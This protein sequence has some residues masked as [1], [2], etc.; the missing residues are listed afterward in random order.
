MANHI[1]HSSVWLFFRS[2][3]HEV[4]ARAA[5]W[6]GKIFF[7]SFFLFFFF[8]PFWGFSLSFSG[9]L[10]IP[11]P[12]QHQSVTP[13]YKAKLTVI[14]FESVQRHMSWSMPVGWFSMLWKWGSVTAV[15]W[16]C[17][18]SVDSEHRDSG[19]AIGK[20]KTEGETRGRNDNGTRTRKDA[21]PP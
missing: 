1:W 4:S 10:P 13:Q 21:H 16:A 18:R 2:F 7:F 6:P 8:F 12:A 14:S 19:L 9:G 11:P 3:S 17:R 20:G 5:A 15:S